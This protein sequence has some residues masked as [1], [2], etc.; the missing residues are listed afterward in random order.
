M[1]VRPDEDGCDDIRADQIIMPRITPIQRLMLNI[2]DKLYCVY[3]DA[4]HHEHDRAK[5]SYLFVCMLN[6]KSYQ[7]VS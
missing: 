5:A 4:Q 2:H 6:E 1:I 7:Y 3:F